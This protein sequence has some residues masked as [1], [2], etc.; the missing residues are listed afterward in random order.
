MQRC[1]LA[2][3]LVALAIVGPAGAAPR[4]GSQGAP[5]VSS[6][7]P[8]FAALQNSST[9]VRISGRIR[10]DSVIGSPRTRSQDA[11]ETRTGGRVQLDVRTQTE[12]GPLR[13]VIRAGSRR[14]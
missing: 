4:K 7:P 13:A 6:C 14:P 2:F 3:G 12:Y 10:A 8:G 9:C 11:I 1:L 5:K